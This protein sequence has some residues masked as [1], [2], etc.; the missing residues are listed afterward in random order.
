MKKF[1]IVGIVALVLVA[2]GAV[3]F[4]MQRTASAQAEAPTVPAIETAARRGGGRR[5]GAGRAG[6]R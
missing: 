1:V 2:G 6:E 3:A 4:T 5:R